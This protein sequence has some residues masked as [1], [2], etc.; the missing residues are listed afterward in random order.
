MTIEGIDVTFLMMVIGG[1]TLCTN[2]V[3]EVVK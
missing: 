3:T 2:V 1:L